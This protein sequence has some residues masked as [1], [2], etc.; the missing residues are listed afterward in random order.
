M[1]VVYSGIPEFLE[2]LQLEV[3][4]RNVDHNVLRVA[5][6]TRSLGPEMAY[7]VLASFSSWM[8]IV[9]LR[10][11]VGNVLYGDTDGGRRLAADANRI[12]QEIRSWGRDRG[13]EVRAGAYRDD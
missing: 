10:Y 1:M 7:T 8:E 3:G 13:L 4:G 11:T 2:E 5:I 6:H 12:A 9:Q